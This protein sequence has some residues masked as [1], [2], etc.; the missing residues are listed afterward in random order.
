V[1]VKA[2]STAAGAAD[3]SLVVQQSPNSPNY[4]TTNGVT[5][6]VDKPLAVSTYAA[7]P[8]GTG[9]TPAATIQAKAS[10]GILRSVYATN[11]TN[12]NTYLMLFNQNGS[13]PNVSNIVG[14]P[15]TLPANGGSVALDEAFFSRYGIYFSTGIL[16]GVSSSG[17]SWSA[18]TAANHDIMGVL[19]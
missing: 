11:R 5:P 2:A 3:K 8:F 4:D 12:A 13:T 17:T 6:M 19:S 18:D 16:I 1:A 14:A 15:I 10:A 7:T 9:V